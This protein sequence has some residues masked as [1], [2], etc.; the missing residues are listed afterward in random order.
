ML[1]LVDQLK[2]L[3]QRAERSRT[4]DPSV[5]QQLRD[6]VRRYD[7]P[8]RARLLSDDFSES[9]Y[10]LEQTWVVDRGDFRV[11]RGQGLRTVFIPQAS[12]GRGSTERRGESPA[13][14]ILGGILKGMTEPGAGSGQPSPP[15]AAEIRTELRISSAFAVRLQLASR[16]RSDGDRRLEFG[17]YQG[18]ERNSGYRLAYNPGK[19]PAFELLRIVPGRS[20]VI[21]VSQGSIDLEDGLAHDL[22]WRRGGDGEMI[23]L[24]DGREILRAMDRAFGDGFNG[25]TI[26]NGGGDYTLSRVEIFGTSR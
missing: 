26:V 3:I 23:V 1:E 22:E 21:E 17:P 18:R 8:W 13:L 20:A 5:L 10:R 9:N 4:S 7:W 14:D 2:E 12:P 19:R 6:L 24:L 25:F 16:A 11:V 15:S